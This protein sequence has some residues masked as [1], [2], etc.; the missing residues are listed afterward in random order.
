MVGGDGISSSGRHGTSSQT[1]LLSPYQTQ[2]G[3]WALPPLP[4]LFYSARDHLLFPP[5]S[6]RRHHIGQTISASFFLHDLSS[7]YLFLST[8]SS[9]L[10]PFCSRPFR[11]PLLSPDPT[12]T[13][14]FSDTPEP[15][16][17]HPGHGLSRV[18]SS[19]L[20]LRQLSLSP[21][22]AVAAPRSDNISAG[23]MGCA[24]SAPNGPIRH[25]ELLCREGGAECPQAVRPTRVGL[26]GGTGRELCWLIGITYV[27]PP[28]NW[29]LFVE[30]G[31]EPCFYPDG[32]ESHGGIHMV[33]LRWM[34]RISIKNCAFR[35]V[36]YLLH[37]VVYLLYHT[38]C[39]S[40]TFAE[41]VLN[42]DSCSFICFDRLAK[43]KKT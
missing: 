9:Q 11:R 12:A 15:P 5:Q 4:S 10:F 21:A 2:G 26:Q 3:G 13:P 27:V 36:L 38:Y 14:S 1:P 31:P 34:T 7:H 16:P 41:A 22:A 8:A 18:T 6:S 37:H 35:T 43:M 24:P 25:L 30:L 33:C 29:V 19:S 17:P 40:M 32:I 23:W 39:I 42:S 20:E 28:G